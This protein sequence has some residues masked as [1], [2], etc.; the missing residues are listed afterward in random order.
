[1]RCQANWQGTA[2]IEPFT[3]GQGDVPDRL[4][5]PQTI[6]GEESDHDAKLVSDR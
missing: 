2:R 5:L 6:T 3:L 4:L 1:M